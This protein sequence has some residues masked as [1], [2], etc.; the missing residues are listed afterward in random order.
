MICVIVFSTISLLYWL[1]GCIDEFILQ[2]GRGNI[3]EIFPNLPNVL[4]IWTGVSQ[5]MIAV[6]VFLIVIGLI[7]LVIILFNKKFCIV[8]KILIIAKTICFVSMAYIGYSWSFK[9]PYPMVFMLM[10]ST[11][12]LISVS[13]DF[14]KAKRVE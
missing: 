4:S 10:F 3:Y 13:F 1:L 12:L 6:Q 11:A 2:Y 9:E 8:S 7:S 5:I 14:I